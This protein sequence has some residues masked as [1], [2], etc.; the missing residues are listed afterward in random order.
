MD[1]LL[2]GLQKLTVSPKKD[3]AFG[4]K[5]FKI[6][7]DPQGNRLTYCKITSGSLH[8]RTMLSGFT[9]EQE[10]WQEKVSQ[11]RRYSGEKF[12]A[13]EAAQQGTVCALTGLTQ[14]VCRDRDWAK[15]RIRKRR[16]WN[17]C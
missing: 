3:A 14:D 6:A 12:Q 5:V 13:L 16:F 7:A 10:I 4:A 1:A 11:I 15:S 9:P 17:Q 2:S 8:V